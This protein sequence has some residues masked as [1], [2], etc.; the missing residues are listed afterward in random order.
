L[1]FLLPPPPLAT[2]SLS[3]EEMRLRATLRLSFFLLFPASPPALPCPFLPRISIERR[4]TYFI[5]FFFSSA[6][7]FCIFLALPVRESVVATTNLPEFYSSL[8]PPFSPPQH[9]ALFFSF[10]LRV[11][12][13]PQRAQGQSGKKL[14]RSKPLFIPLF[15][16]F[17]L[18]AASTTLFPP[19]C[20]LEA[21]GW[22]FAARGVPDA[23][24]SFPIFL[25]S[26]SSCFFPPPFVTVDKR[27]QIP[28]LGGYPLFQLF[29][30]RFSFSAH[31]SQRYGMPAHDPSLS[32]I[33]FSL[34]PP[35][36]PSLHFFSL[37]K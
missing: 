2:R 18:P 14:I 24:F 9:V 33:S 28:F 21:R 25:F 10:S 22:V 16:P 35:F 20:V 29:P 5:L 11:S 1:A 17:S 32:Y 26:A 19:S 4:Y 13:L 12:R 6:S 34:F 36:H 7:F 31:F 37:L 8:P 15:P 3:R 23:P 27:E 30:L